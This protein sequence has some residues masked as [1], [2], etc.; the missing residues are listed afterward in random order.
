[1]KKHISDDLRG[2]I[3]ET[4]NAKQFL[5][6][7]LEELLKDRRN[8]YEKFFTLTHKRKLDS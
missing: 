4:D 6:S 2:E 5:A 8:N 1:M 3:P 7:L